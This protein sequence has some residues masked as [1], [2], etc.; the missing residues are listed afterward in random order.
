MTRKL[1]NDFN[2]ASD[3]KKW[4]FENSSFLGNSLESFKEHEQK[5]IMITKDQM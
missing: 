1:L 5:R 2:K 3:K 4:V